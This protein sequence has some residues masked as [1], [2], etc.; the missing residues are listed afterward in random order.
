MKTVNSAAKAPVHWAFFASKGDARE[1]A[2]L[3]PG[4]ILYHDGR[5][6]IV[7]YRTSIFYID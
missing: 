4:A 5:D 6:W 7:A 3:H 1:H 2:D